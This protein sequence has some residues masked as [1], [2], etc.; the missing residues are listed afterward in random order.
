WAALQN[1]IADTVE[2]CENFGVETVFVAFHPNINLFGTRQEIEGLIHRDGVLSTEN[3]HKPFG[4]DGL[5]IPFL[6]SQETKTAIK[7][8]TSICTNRDFKKY[9]CENNPEII[10]ITGL[11]EHT[12]DQFGWCINQSAKDIRKLLD[13]PEVH[14]V[15]E[16]TNGNFLYGRG[17][18]HQPY[19][20]PT[21]QERKEFFSRFGIHVTPFSQIIE[22]I[23][24]TQHVAKTLPV[25]PGEISPFLQRVYPND[26]RY[27]GH[28]SV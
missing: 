14:I 8:R 21:L 18:E 27:N 25:R 13:D 5:A 24:D 9:I 1:N 6:P 22:R 15:A 11:F 19:Y 4:T 20:Q 28:P 3:P 2:A 10:I 16:A 12:K 17:V 23:I 7:N 26:L